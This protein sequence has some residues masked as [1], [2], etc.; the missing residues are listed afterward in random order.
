MPLAPTSS[1]QVELDLFQGPLYTL[2][3]LIERREL[4]VTRVSLV[5]VADQYLALV[6]SSPA[7][8][9]DLTAEFLHVAVRLLLLK[10]LALL[11]RTVEDEPR[12][13]GDEEADLAA[14]LLLYRR[15]RDGARLL[16]ARQE[17]GLCAFG[18][19]APGDARVQVSSAPG[20]PPSS[21]D[22]RRL[23][24]AAQRML[25]RSTERERATAAAPN[26]QVPF[27]QVLH[28]VVARLR[29]R[30]RATFHDIAGEA[31]DTV[32]AITMFLAILELVRRQRLLMR[33]QSRFG[34]IV[35]EPATDVA[36]QAGEPATDVAWQAAE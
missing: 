9:L 34:P 35:L 30:D 6:H 16:A 31:A 27:A 8:D 11:P 25:A 22:P 24:R 17:A 7:L 13:E 20:L 18:R 19:V 3:D 4:P 15:Y 1:L 26:P 12:E 14:R 23:R 2:L 32:T 33:Q 28:A 5:A 36:W 21:L 29:G 10:S